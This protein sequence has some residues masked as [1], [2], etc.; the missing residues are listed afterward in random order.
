MNDSHSAT[1]INYVIHE[2]LVFYEYIRVR[3]KFN[4]R[5]K[6]DIRSIRMRIL[7]I[8]QWLTLAS[9][10]YAPIKTIYISYLIVHFYQLFINYSI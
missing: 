7:F 1:Y 10:G 2:Y 8:Y 3:T 6:Q 9:L 5:E 4:F